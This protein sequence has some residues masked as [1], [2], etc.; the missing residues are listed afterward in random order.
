MRKLTIIFLFLAVNVWF[1]L[2][3]TPPSPITPPDT[4]PDV[5]ANMNF[6]ITGGSV[7]VAESG[8]CPTGTYTF[9]WNGEHSSG[10]TFACFDSGNTSD[11]PDVASGTMTTG[12]GYGQ[13]NLGVQLSQANGWWEWLVSE[14]GIIFE[15]DFTVCW[16]MR[17]NGDVDPTSDTNMWESWIDS[18]NYAEGRIRG[19]DDA[20]LEARA[21]PNSAEHAP[22]GVDVT[23]GNWHRICASGNSATGYL[24]ISTDGGEPV[25]LGTN[26]TTWTPINFV[27]GEDSAGLHEIELHVDNVFVMSGY[28][29]TDPY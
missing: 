5:V 4:I 13:D 26:Y 10:V 29:Q 20:I 2:G 18:S 28:Q 17:T 23:D 25:V 6:G 22:G 15:D 1:A 24:S 9:A 7:P 3:W 27:I 21:T 8:D 19:N 12:T 16:S 14:Q 11:S